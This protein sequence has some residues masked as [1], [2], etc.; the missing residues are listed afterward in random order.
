MFFQFFHVSTMYPKVMYPMYPDYPCI[1]SNIKGQTYLTVT[2]LL[3]CFSFLIYPPY[4]HLF[5]SL[6]LIASLIII[7]SIDLV[8]LISFSY[9]EGS[10]RRFRAHFP[11]PGF[12]PAFASGCENRPT[13]PIECPSKGQIYVRLPNLR[14]N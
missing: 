6:I 2:H 4:I 8:F 1:Q 11:H 7:A 12:E 3:V 14:P 10:N 13:P 9:L 5:Q